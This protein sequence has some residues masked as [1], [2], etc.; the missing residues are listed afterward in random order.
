MGSALIFGVGCLLPPV[1]AWMVINQDWMFYI[2]VL[3]IVYKPWRLFLIVCGLPGFVS[4]FVLMFL[5]ESP[6]FVLGLGDPS[7][8]LKILEK[9]NRWNGG[10]K[11]ALEMFEICEE[12]ESIANRRRIMDNKNSRFPLIK[13]VWDQTAP[14]FKPP[15][16]GSTLLIC[17]I[18]FMV[19]VTSNGVYMWFPDIVNRV[20]SRLED[21]GDDRIKICEAIH[22]PMNTSMLEDE[23]EQVIYLKLLILHL[24]RVRKTDLYFDCTRKNLF[25]V[26]A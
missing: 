6:R 8:A 13:S 23:S 5:P 19:Y 14:L 24:S 2:P 15:Y 26:R 20:A 7:G 9:M 12:A 11:D 21:I 4:F 1:I 25:C 3:D 16:L 17:S 18:Q 22:L 10:N